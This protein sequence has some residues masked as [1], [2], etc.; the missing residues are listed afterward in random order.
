VSNW[1]FFCQ[2]VC[3]GQDAGSYFVQNWE[4]AEELRESYTS[5]PGVNPHGYSEQHA[6]ESGHKRAVIVT[7]AIGYDSDLPESYVDLSG[8]LL[9]FAGRRNG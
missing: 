3:C 4:R 2:L 1:G 6:H 9:A 7:E 5:G 8:R